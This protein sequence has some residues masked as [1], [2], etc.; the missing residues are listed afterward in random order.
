ME[1]TREVQIVQNQFS[2]SYKSNNIKLPIYPQKKP[3]TKILS[4]SYH[5]SKD[6][7]PAENLATESAMIT[8][9][10]EK[11]DFYPNHKFNSP[12]GSNKKIKIK[13]EYRENKIEKR[14]FKENRHNVLKSNPSPLKDYYKNH[15]YF[16]NTRNRGENNWE[17]T[18]NSRINYDG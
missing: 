10:S 12:S 5:F 15:N 18:Q 2:Q 9:A 11:G 13:K 16:E 4:K 6:L 3:K 14:E 8:S 17:N 7:Q 1:N